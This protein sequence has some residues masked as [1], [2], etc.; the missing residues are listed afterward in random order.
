MSYTI[1]QVAERTGLSIH[2]LRYYEKEGILPSV[3]RSESGMRS[4]VDKDL[5]ALEFISCLRALGMSISD[6]KHFVQESTSIDLRLG[7]LERQNENVTSQINQLFA[8][9]AM[10]HRKIDLYRNMRK[11][12]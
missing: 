10:I 1:G 11:E 6:I 5:E 7:I 4:Y 9:Q 3:M 8:Y 2:T 12:E